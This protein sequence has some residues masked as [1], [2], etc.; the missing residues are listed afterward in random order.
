MLIVKKLSAAIA[1]VSPVSF[2]DDVS[3]T[4]ESTCPINVDDV[5]S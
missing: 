5:P 2:D 1:I 4:V 3:S